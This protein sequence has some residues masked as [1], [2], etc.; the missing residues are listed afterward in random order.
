MKC[1]LIKLSSLVALA[2]RTVE[3]IGNLGMDAAAT[4]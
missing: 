3:Q 4:Q 2:D 1:I